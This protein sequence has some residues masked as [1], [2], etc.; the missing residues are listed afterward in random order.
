VVAAIVTIGPAPV[1]T[2]LVARGTPMGER[3]RAKRYYDAVREILLREWDPIG[4]PDVPEA[5]NEYDR[6]VDRLCVMIARQEPGDRIAERLWRIETTG[7]GLRGD[8]QRAER[9]ADRLIGLRGR[10]Q[11]GR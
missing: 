5:Q 3:E 2:A 7:M 11:A 1:H 9:V 10:H 6:Y 8:R 4:V